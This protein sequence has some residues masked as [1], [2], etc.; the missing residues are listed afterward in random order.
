MVPEVL[1]INSKRSDRV[2]ALDSTSLFIQDKLYVMAGKSKEEY[3]EIPEN[4]IVRL[5]IKPYNPE[6]AN[7]RH[8]FSDWSPELI[9]KEITSYL[10]R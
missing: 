3:P 9:V 8:F 2:R 5:D 6:F 1:P 10:N 7:P 4:H